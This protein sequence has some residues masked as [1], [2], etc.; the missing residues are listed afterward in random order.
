MYATHDNEI[1]AR[2]LHLPPEKNKLPLE[3]DDQSLR[4][5][6]VEYQIEN[7]NIYDIL[8]KICKDTDLYPYIK[9]HKSKRD[10]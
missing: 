5:C 3:H 10:G 1:I 6:M 2:M 7:K 8:D 4:A 9:Q